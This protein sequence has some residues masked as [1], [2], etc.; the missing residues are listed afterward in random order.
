MIAKSDQLQRSICIS[1]VQLE[2][3]LLDALQLQ[4]MKP[5]AQQITEKAKG[6]EKGGLNYYNFDHFKS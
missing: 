4:I 3:A 1:N 6:K 5:I 2:L